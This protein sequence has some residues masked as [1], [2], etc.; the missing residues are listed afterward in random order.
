MNKKYLAFAT[1]FFITACSE[2]ES[3]NNKFS[4]GENIDEKVT[5]YADCIKTQ[6]YIC[7]T[8]FMLPS[9][10]QSV[11]GADKMVTILSR[12][13][14]KGSSKGLIIDPSKTTYGT[15]GKI[16]KDKKELVSVIP[17]VQHGTYKGS[18]A[19][20]QASL[21]AFSNDNGRSWFFLEGS[22]ENQMVIANQNPRLLQLISIPMPIMKFDNYTFIQKNGEWVNVVSP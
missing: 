1:I 13:A 15:H 17:Y 6:N 9:L 7:A 22:D 4:S 8:S 10:V 14:E 11:G 18:D 16:V 20:I 19:E 3:S 2:M 5:Q 12:I 21:I